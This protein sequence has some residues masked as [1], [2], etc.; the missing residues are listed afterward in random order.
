MVQNHF[1]SFFSNP[2]LLFEIIVGNQGIIIVDFEPSIHRS[3]QAPKPS[4][5]PSSSPSEDSPMKLNGNQ[6]SAAETKKSIDNNHLL[7]I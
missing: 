7:Q 5:M 3:R 6:P 1:K 4:S 2:K